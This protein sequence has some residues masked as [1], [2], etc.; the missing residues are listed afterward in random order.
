MKRV[1]LKKGMCVLIAGALTVSAVPMA[2]Y[3]A[4]ANTEKEEVIYVNLNDDGT[5]EEINVVNIL[6]P[7]EGSQVIDYGAY[8]SVRNMT[9]TEKIDYSDDVVR[10][11]T[12]AEKLYYE[13]KLDDT[14]IPW[15]IQI[16]YYL[17]GKEYSAQ[18]LA[19]RSGALK[20][21][22][23]I[24]ENQK[25]KG[26]FYDNYALQASVTLDTDRCK[27]ISAP[28][29][30]AA[31]VG[32]DKQLTYTIL[33]GK[34]ADIEITTDVSDF[35][36]SGISMN[37]IPLNLDVEVDD[38]E[39]MDQVT[40]LIDAI[41]KL[42]DGASDLQE[43]VSE[44]Q[45]GASELQ[46]GASE[47]QDGASK[48][49][50]AA[51]EDLQS[52]VRDLDDGAGQLQSGA[53]SLKS[54]G[55]S[56]ESGAGSLRNGA[57]ALDDGIQSLND[58]I[59]QVQAGLD[60]LNSQSDSLTGG[61]AQMKKALA[62]LQAA[63]N[64]VSV[65]AEDVQ[66]LSQASAEIH[67]GIDSLAEGASQLQGQASFEAY[68]AVMAQNGLDIDQLRAGNADA[69]GA[70][71]G[72]LGQVGTVEAILGQY[73]IPAEAYAGLEE[74][75]VALANQII[76]LLNTNNA[77]IDGIQGYMGGVNQGA[78]AL[79]VGAE[80]LK[81]N[82]T[83][84]DTAIHTL[85]DT[86]TELVYQMSE[87]QKAVNQ[88]VKEYEKLDSGINAYTEGVAQ[89]VAG[90][91]RVSGGAYSLTQGSGELRNGSA[92]LYAGTAEL[93]DGIV[94]LYDATGSLKDGTGR[95]DEGVA[96]L[97]T[98][99]ASLYDGTGELK[100]GTVELKDGTGKLKDGTVELKDGTGEL[101]TETSGMDKE[102]QDKI[103][104]LLDS[105]SGGNAE[106]TSFVSEKNT[107][108]DSVQF[109]IKTNSIQ[110]TEAVEAAAVPVRELT[111]WQKFLD[112]FGLYKED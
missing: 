29:A 93:L 32:S 46:D 91:S 77:A 51:K 88:L 28:D 4:E 102:I 43:G 101:K 18:E 20:I 15:D 45:D 22:V 25:Y 76:V 75:C 73:N 96:E 19:G 100:D 33:P 78:A 55:Q 27:N 50:D 13:G 65:T 62:Q 49:Q 79:A 105:V 41:E 90:Y 17:D 95:L 35:E 42:D 112:L 24:A 106:I 40:E 108:I 72:M 71:Q 14:V 39:L 94:E 58:G 12:S 61:S 109:V 44:L 81:L 89:V 82:Y 107:N 1:Y 30:T 99:I 86:L 53:G 69:A 87:L 37:G 66:K 47:F 21:T 3:A 34:G 7:G 92:S 63:L 83:E 110:E 84:F 5:V 85:V 16:R 111:A 60:S 64:G 67:K 2:A 38:E 98:G 57:A 80:E 10:I 31:N 23:K 104:E 70:V 74:Q 6:T 36:M 103:D 56:V 52:G 97:I 54:G 11:D 8:Q 48:L 26:I 68:K 9:T 59:W